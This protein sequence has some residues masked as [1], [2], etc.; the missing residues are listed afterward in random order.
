MRTEIF[1]IDFDG[2]CVTHAYPKIG[3]SIGA[4]D[5]LRQLVAKGHRLI[6]FT[7]R[8]GDTLKEAVDWF[9]EKDIPLFGINENPE[10]KSWTSSPKPYCNTYIDDAALGCPLVFNKKVPRERPWVDWPAVEHILKS[11]N[12]I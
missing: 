5:V 6:L 7:M 2:T 9:K 8:S 12:L 1:G 3:F 4:E 10:Q 11:R